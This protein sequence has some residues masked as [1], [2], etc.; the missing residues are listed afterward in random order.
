MDFMVVVFM[1]VVFMKVDFITVVPLTEGCPR[2]LQR[3]AGHSDVSLSFQDVKWFW[4][5]WHRHLS[6]KANVIRLWSS[7]WHV[8]N[9]NM[10]I[11][12]W[13][14]SMLVSYMPYVAGY[15]NVYGK[16]SRVQ[17][18]D[19]MYFHLRRQKLSQG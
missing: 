3:A 16:S 6:S 17:I 15:G 13:L 7:S 1:A 14:T 8:F 18:G 19:G 5:N 12:D 4:M 9:S 2:P 11:T 10:T